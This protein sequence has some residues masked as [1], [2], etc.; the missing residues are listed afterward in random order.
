MKKLRG[1]TLAE[2]MIALVVLGVLMAVVTPA[3]MST[4]P[5]KN[6]MM[7]KKAY[8]VAEGIVSNLINNPALYPD[9]TDNC[10]ADPAPTA[11]NPC[12]W[13]FDDKRQVNSG[14]AQSTDLNGLITTGKLNYTGNNKFNLLFAEHLNVK[15]VDATSTS[16]NSVTTNDGMQ[17]FFSRTSWPAPGTVPNTA[18]WIAAG[19]AAVVDAR[20]AVGGANHQ[21]DSSGRKIILVDANGDKG[22]NG[23]EKLSSN[24]G[25]NSPQCSTAAAQGDNFDQFRIMIFADGRMQI[26]PDDARASEYVTIGASVQKK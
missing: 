18:E 15:A 3:I 8:Y 2:L 1:F 20:T 21:L 25:A 14:G 17:W 12:Y 24:S 19:D 26:H 23:C 4:R 10:V 6:K 22:P 11:D 5:D 7:I 9:N 13:G 16:L